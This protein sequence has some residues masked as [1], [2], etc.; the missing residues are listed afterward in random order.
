MLSAETAVGEYPVEAVADD[1][2]RSRA[3]SSRASATGTSCPRPS[4]QP[5]SATRCRTPRATSPRRSARGRSSCRRSAAARRRSSRGCARAGRSSGSRHHQYALQQM[6]LEWGVMPLLIAGGA[7]RRGPLGACRSS[8]ARERGLVDAGRPRRA[9]RGHRGEHPRLDERDQGRRRVGAVDRRRANWARRWRRPHG[10]RPARASPALARGRRAR[11]R[12]RSSTA[13]RSARYL[14][15]RDA[16]RPR[17]RPR[18][19]CSRSAAQRSSGGSRTSRARPTLAREARRLGLVKPGEQLFIVKGIPAWRAAK[20][21]G[22]TLARGGRSR[23]S[24]SAS[25]AGAPRAFRRVAVRCPFGR[26][27]VTEQ[28]PFD[29]NGEPFPT[30]FWLTCPHLVAAIS[31]L[32]AAGG[33]ERWTRARAGGPRARREPRG[34]ARRAA[35]AAPRAAVRDRRRDAHRQPQVPARPRGVRARASRVRARRRILAEVEPLWP[36]DHCCM[37]EAH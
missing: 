37:D 11:A 36:T 13:S 15:A 4:E 8:A 22:T 31:R 12:R 2:P 29:D 17:G 25:S 14:H 1:G 26:P 3:R 6:A 9:H 5:T 23:R 34:R 32:E 35:A 30:T 16:A 7:E 18:W 24:S 10:D 28:A 19:P 33:V 20:R 21:T 27:A